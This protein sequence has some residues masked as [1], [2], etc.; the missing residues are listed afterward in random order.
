MTWHSDRWPGIHTED[1]DSD[2]GPS[3]QTDD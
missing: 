1:L 2:R 3:I